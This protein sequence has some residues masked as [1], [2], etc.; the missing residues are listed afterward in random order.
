LGWKY[1]NLWWI[2]DN[3]NKKSFIY[4]N[5]V[6]E[7]S[8]S[9]PITSFNNSSNVILWWQDRSWYYFSW[10]IDEVRIYNRILSD[11]EISNLYNATK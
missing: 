3:L 7:N 6:L 9:S 10:A 2:F 8:V 1:Y 11:S 5:W 4:I